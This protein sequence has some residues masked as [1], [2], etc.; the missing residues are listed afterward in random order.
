ML[1]DPG[2]EA[3]ALLRSWLEAVPTTAH[4][5]PLGP[6]LMAAA[7]RAESRIAQL[8]RDV[9]A[10][11]KTAASDRSLTAEALRVKFGRGR[12]T[13]P[14]TDPEHQALSALS[15]AGSGWDKQLLEALTAYYQRA[16]RT[17]LLSKE[18][19]E[20]L[21]AQALARH[22]EMLRTFGSGGPPQPERPRQQRQQR[23]K[24]M[25]EVTLRR[26]A[27]NFYDRVEEV[28]REAVA[29]KHSTPNREPADPLAGIPAIRPEATF[30]A[31]LLHAAGCA[32]LTVLLNGDQ[33]AAEAAATEHAARILPD[34]YR[35][36]A[37]EMDRLADLAR[38][39]AESRNTAEA[40]GQIYRAE[41]PLLAL[42]RRARPD[43]DP[44]PEWQYL[45]KG[46]KGRRA[47]QARLDH[48][49]ELAREAEA[50][51]E[52]HEL[53]LSPYQQAERRA[54]YAY[55]GPTLGWDADRL[56]QLWQEFNPDRAIP[57]S[58]RVMAP[59]ATD[60]ARDA[61]RSEGYLLDAYRGACDALRDQSEGGASA[62][63]QRRRHR[64]AHE[65][66]L[67]YQS[68]AALA[69]NLIRACGIEPPPAE[70]PEPLPA[71]EEDS[72]PRGTPLT[73]QAMP[74]TGIAVVPKRTKPRAAA[75]SP[76][77]PEPSPAGAPLELALT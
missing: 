52:I 40:E 30:D 8:E 58:W 39:H 24:P 61:V 70:E 18:T 73:Q 43:R 37:E 28:V 34:I 22:R 45:M 16:L 49:T 66:L 27:K 25:S 5:D 50:H 74:I 71:I 69:E 36:E 77:R 65:A 53:E 33:A 56:Q 63:T 75:A 41:K 17:T 64:E 55:R 23:P 57:R 35:Q 72:R 1:D 42:W 29:V 4:Q 59:D 76:R 67:A 12:L 62:A 26:L 68:T 19:P 20:A 21:A 7:R 13:D 44:D 15:E 48:L 9:R 54:A 11:R 10:Y 38:Y 14:A 60:E 32:D 46:A 51:L 31:F 47:R 6:A 2:T 3:A